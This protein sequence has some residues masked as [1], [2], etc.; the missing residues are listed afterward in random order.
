MCWAIHVCF[1]LATSRGI[2]FK[3]VLGSVVRHC[4]PRRAAR[5]Y[6]AAFMWVPVWAGIDVGVV[7]AALAL[8][9]TGVLG[10]NQLSNMNLV[11]GDGKGV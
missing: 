11:S 1:L 5:P 8:E 4:L 3:Y 9:Q 7:C 6:I 2:T 10:K